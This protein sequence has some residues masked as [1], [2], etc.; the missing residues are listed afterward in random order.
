MGDM[1]S[2]R[3]R[4]LEMKRLRDPAPSTEDTGL[5]TRD[6][7]FSPFNLDRRFVFTH[8]TEKPF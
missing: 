1:K 3:L 8:L 5:R 7:Y 2:G 4:D 6:L